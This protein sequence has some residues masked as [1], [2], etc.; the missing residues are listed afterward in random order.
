MP[1]Q[2]REF[3]LIRRLFDRQVGR[4]EEVPV[5]IGDDAAVCLVP[6]GAALVT[7]TDS[8]VSGTHFTSDADPASVG[9]R[10][11]AV[12]LSDIAAMGAAPKW[13]SLALNLP[14]IDNPWLDAF[15]AAFFALA[16]DHNVIL[17]GGDTVRGPLSV[18]VTVQGLVPSGQ[19]ILRSG[20]MAGDL[21]FVTGQPGSAA[22][23]RLYAD[24]NLS[25]KFYF[26]EPRVQI[27]QSLQGIASAMIDISDGLADDLGHLLHAS[28]GGATLDIEALPVAAGVADKLSVTEVAELGLF[29]GEDFELCFCIPP[30]KETELIELSAS[31]PVSVTRIGTVNN[32]AA[33]VW[34]LG[35]RVFEPAATSFKHFP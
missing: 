4:N 22:F 24:R 8:L 23:A 18:T 30:E 35:G 6:D 27:G 33:L 11:L 17:I 31:W 14:H 7:A 12:N 3:E 34:R 10:C 25:R 5:G 21:I 9:H 2:L 29:G 20:A 16:D 32:S 13:A 15:S 26:P 1:E 28:G 19:A